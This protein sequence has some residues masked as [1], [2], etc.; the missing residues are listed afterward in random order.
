MVDT[1]GALDHQISELRNEWAR[2]EM[3]GGSNGNFEDIH[4]PKDWHHDSN[5]PTLLREMIGTRLIQS[6]DGGKW[7]VQR[8]MPRLCTYDLTAGPEIGA[9][10][11]RSWVKWKTGA[12]PLWR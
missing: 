4:I 5:W 8:Y 12:P 11:C 2:I 9:V 1:E 10:V 7:W 6:D 3:S